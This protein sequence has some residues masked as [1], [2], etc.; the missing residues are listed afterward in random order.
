MITRLQHRPSLM[1]PWTVTMPFASAAG[2]TSP[3]RGTMAR[4]CAASYHMRPSRSRFGWR[5]PRPFCGSRWMRKDTKIT[6]LWIYIYIYI[7][8]SNGAW[9][10]TSSL[11]LFNGCDACISRVYSKII[12]E[13]WHVATITKKYR[14]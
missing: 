14:V 12:L 13:S 8:E 2:L 9:I 5:R 3:F 11:S 10:L 7:F 4:N 1:E 6:R